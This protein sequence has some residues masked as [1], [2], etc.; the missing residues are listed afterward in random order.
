MSDEIHEIDETLRNLYPHWLRL[1][2]ASAYLG[3]KRNTLAQRFYRSLGSRKRIF[4]TIDLDAWVMNAPECVPT[5]AEIGRLQKM[6][7]G[8]ARA[9]ERRRA[10]RAAKFEEDATA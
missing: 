4:K 5:P 9:L 10:R 8:A 7:A 1:D 3:L 6:Q 2:A